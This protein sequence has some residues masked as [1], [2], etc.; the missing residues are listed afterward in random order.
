M[1]PSDRPT[2]AA[3]ALLSG[4]ASGSDVADGGLT[5]NWATC[6]PSQTQLRARDLRW[7]RAAVAC[8]PRG[9]AA[10]HE[11]SCRHQD[12]TDYPQVLTDAL[13]L[14]ASVD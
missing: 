13:V 10:R 2:N 4:T 6:N 5:A 11:H 12:H 7:G 14:L 8:K 9:R 3:A 1:Q